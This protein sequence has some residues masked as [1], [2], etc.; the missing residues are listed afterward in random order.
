MDA[1]D[2]KKTKQTQEL[3]SNLGTLE[4]LELLMMVTSVA[5]KTDKLMEFCEMTDKLELTYVDLLTVK[6]CDFHWT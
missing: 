2:L 3:R 4:S 5:M 6:A 1:I